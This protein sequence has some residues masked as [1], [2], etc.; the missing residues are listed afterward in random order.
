MTYKIKTIA[1]K[2][3]RSLLDITLTIDTNVNTISIC[4]GNNTGKTNILRA[5]NLFFH[6]DKYEPKEDKPSHKVASGGGST[7]PEIS[8]GFADS[9]SSD[10]YTITRNLTLTT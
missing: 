10:I 9:N 6:P 8:I 5:I 7:S 1:V 3:F 4:G 2:R